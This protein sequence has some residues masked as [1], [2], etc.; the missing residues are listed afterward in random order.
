M[1]KIDNPAG[2]LLSILEEG[3]RLKNNLS[4]QGAWAKLLAVDSQNTSLLL[5]RIG[6]VISLPNQIRMKIQLVEN[7][8]HDVLTEGLPSIESTLSSINLN[9]KWSDIKRGLSDKSLYSLKV[10][11]S[12]LS[13]HVPD[14]TIDNETLENI[15][16]SNKDLIQEIFNSRINTELKDYLLK[17]LNAIEDAIQQYVIYGSENIKLALERAYGSILT[18]SHVSK[19]SL[20]EPVGKKVWSF[21]NRIAVIITL[22]TNLPAIDIEISKL[23]E[24]PEFT[25]NEQAVIREEDEN[26]IGQV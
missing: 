16:S 19:R 12:T 24:L 11:S 2:R 9:S 5:Q 23:H 4:V 15:R 21:L 6:G 3:M 26:D 17:H 18:E 25:L 7:V 14:K 20:E 22:T 13:S 10:C 1:T 8:D